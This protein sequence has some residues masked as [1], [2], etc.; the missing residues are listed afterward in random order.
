MNMIMLKGSDVDR[1]PITVAEALFPAHLSNQ[2]GGK[3][4]DRHGYFRLSAFGSGRKVT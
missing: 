3:R 2:R 4:S 1:T